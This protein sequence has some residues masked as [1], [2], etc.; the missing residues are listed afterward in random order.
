MIFQEECFR[1]ESRQTHENMYISRI[2]SW[3]ACIF[4]GL[5][6]LGYGVVRPYCKYGTIMV[7]DTFSILSAIMGLLM[8]F[9]FLYPIVPLMRS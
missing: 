4:A 9:L 5:L 1:D 8:L 7:F 2:T 3:G 6:E